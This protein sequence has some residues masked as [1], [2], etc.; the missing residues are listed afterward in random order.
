LATLDIFEEDDVLMRNRARAEKMTQA[1]STLANHPQVKHFRNRGMIWAFDA[2][3][4]DAAEAATFSRR[5]F[6]AALQQ[7]LLVRPIGTTVYLMPPYILE[8]EETELLAT[9]TASVFGQ[10]MKEA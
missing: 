2:V 9:R 4:Q 8:N 3:I 10:V 1:L 6:S 5:F 7:E